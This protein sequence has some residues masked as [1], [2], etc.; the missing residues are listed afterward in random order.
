MKH[1]ERR[2]KQIDL[3]EEEIAA[4][5]DRIKNKN[6]TDEDIA[7]FGQVLT[8]MLWLQQQIQHFKISMSKLKNMLFGS[9]DESRK[10]KKGKTDPS[11]AESADKSNNG[12]PADGSNDVPAAESDDGSATSTPQSNTAERDETKPKPKGHGRYGADAYKNAI[13]VYVSH[14]L[15]KPGDLCPEK[16]GGKLYEFEA[17]SVIRVKGQSCA[18]VIHYQF[19]ILRCALCNKQFR[20]EPPKDFSDD[21]YDAEFKSGLVVKKYFLA[22]PFYRQEQY[23]RMIGFPLSDATQWEL[24]E[25]VADCVYPVMG[26]LEMLAANGANIN[27]DD[28]RVKILSVI[29]ENKLMPDKKRTGMFTTCVIAENAGHQI[30]LYYSGIKHSGENIEEIL[31]K[32][33]EGLPPIKQMCDALAANVPTTLKTILCN[34]L[35]HGRR[36]FVDI[37]NFF[38]AECS[39]VI[40]KLAAVYR[41]DTEAKELKLSPD[42]RLEH[43]KKFSAPVMSELKQWMQEQ[44]DLR[45]VEPNSALG[46]AIE[47]MQN[48]WEKL[49]R[50]LTVS[51]VHIDNNI[52]ERALKLAI[53]TRKNA[54]F[55]KT[56]HGAYVGS[57][58]MSLIATCILSGKNALEYL[59]A[60]Q[61]NKTA[62]F[63]APNLWLPW[64][65]ESALAMTF[66]QA[67]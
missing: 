61:K 53:R 23:Y 66:D 58:L 41:Y 13:N 4:L 45:T 42:Q 55:H 24:V 10:N 38:P 33:D 31:K 30:C 25:S 22:T 27:N 43:H 1:K 65:Y 9:K 48:H 26:A 5:N 52:V 57:L 19:E 56:L 32:R 12:A 6:L 59:T 34:C 47:Y 20:A 62:V 35:A 14:K 60:L 46:G 7:L 63:R 36:K 49:T 21:K 8:F 51:G 28:T 54:M 3:T 67:A 44:F 18:H 29:K 50:F 15:L 39:F 37:E 64:N 40:D 16:C 17:G 11:A 2:P